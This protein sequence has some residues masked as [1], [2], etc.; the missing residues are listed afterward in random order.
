MSVAKEAES[1]KRSQLFRTVDALSIKSPRCTPR[2]SVSREHCMY[3]YE[4]EANS[5]HLR[6][7]AGGVDATTVASVFSLA[8]PGDNCATGTAQYFALRRSRNWLVRVRT[9]MHYNIVASSPSPRH[10][11]H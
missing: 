6:S 11:A 8:I 3:D 4:V 10:F 2:D 7:P 5:K 1:Q 9:L